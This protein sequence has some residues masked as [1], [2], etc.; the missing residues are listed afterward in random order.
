[1]V[2]QLLCVLSPPFLH[3]ITLSK[4]L[5]WSYPWWQAFLQWSYQKVFWW[6]WTLLCSFLFCSALQSSHTLKNCSFMSLQACF[7]KCWF[8]VSYLAVSWSVFACYCSWAISMACWE[9][10]SESFYL[11]LG[12][13]LFAALLMIFFIFPQSSFGLSDFSQCLESVGYHHCILLGYF[14]EVIPHRPWGFLHDLQLHLQLC[15]EQLMIQVTIC[16]R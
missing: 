2:V 10:N 1:M 7:W 5:P 15:N 6:L 4:H 13:C 8:S 14:A 16:P 11:A 9:R 3:L 12:M